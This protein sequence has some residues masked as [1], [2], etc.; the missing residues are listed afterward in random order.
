MI[1][2]QTYIPTVLHTC[3]PAYLHTCMP[4]DLQTYASTQWKHNH[5]QKVFEASVCLGPLLS[6]W[7]ATSKLNPCK[8]RCPCRP[9]LYSLLHATPLEVPGA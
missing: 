4:T 8:F 1:S 2:L 6:A 5:I 3:T 9:F 7:A